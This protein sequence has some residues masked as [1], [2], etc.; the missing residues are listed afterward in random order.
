MSFQAFMLRHFPGILKQANK[1]RVVLKRLRKA[2]DYAYKSKFYH[3]KLSKAG[4]KGSDIKSIKDFKEK[5]PLTNRTELV[6]SDPYDLLAVEPGS[7]CLIYS[8]TSGTTGGHVP[9]WV[10][11]DELER[12]ID[13]ALCLP[14]FQKLL[15]SK[16][17]VALCYPY[18]RTMAGRSAD[19]INQKAGVTIIPMG[20]RNNMYPPEEVADALIRLR[21]TILGAAATDAF[22]YANIL[23]DQGVD[24][25]KIGIKLIVSGAEPCADNRGDVLGRMYGAK[26]LSLLGQNEIGGA[27][28]CEKNVLHI[29]SFVMF[30]ELYRKDGSEAD[31]GEK[32][33]SVVTPTWREAMPMLRYETG[34]VIM[35]EKNPCSCGLPLP[36]MKILGRKRTEL[37]IGTKTYFPIE[38]ED[39]LYQTDLNGVWYQIKLTKAGIFIKAEHRKKKDYARLAEE[40]KSNFESKLDANVKV[41]IVPPGTLYDYRKIRPGKPLSRVVDEIAGKIEVLEGA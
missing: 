31:I 40:V 27:I 32:A 17:R 39:L 34:D 41:K 18:T 28:P 38:L 15:S 36:T 6:Q 23:L 33:N 14:V 35:I 22:S 8:Q 13:L 20:T 30:T 21:P 3:K 25:K 2:V 10:T 24:P 12:T 4:V 7:K 11:K 37:T 29:P 9:I 16:D 19:L 26:F 5:V 1:E